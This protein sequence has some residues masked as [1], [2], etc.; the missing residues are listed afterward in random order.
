MFSRVV[1]ESCLVRGRIVGGELFRK[2]Q[3]Q[4]MRSG[5]AA[6]GNPM[7]PRDIAPTIS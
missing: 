3:L 4:G 7:K 5:G 6:V 1:L 2:L